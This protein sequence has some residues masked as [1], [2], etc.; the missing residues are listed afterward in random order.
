MPKIHYFQRY[1]KVEN[2]VTNNTLQLIARI[3]EYS[4]AQASRLLSELTGEAVEIGFEIN[5]QERA[6]ESVPDGAIIQRSFKILIESKVDSGI[7]EDQLLR[8]AKTF[9]NESQKI[10]LLLSVQK[11]IPGHERELANQI[12]TANGT[13]IIFRNVTY[14]EICNSIRDLFREYEY[15]MKTLVEDYIEYCNDTGLFDQSRHL[16]RIVPCSDSVD[17]NKKYGIYFHSSDRGYTNHSYVGIYAGK[18]V[19]CLWQLD[20]VFDVEYD[21]VNLTKT[22][23]QGKDTSDYDERIKNII[24]ES[25]KVCGYNVESGHRFFCGKKAIETDYSKSTPYGILSP[26]FINVKDVVGQFSD[27]EDLAIKLKGKTWE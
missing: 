4:N 22:L 12:S 2:M 17:L 6:N 25:K 16:M 11:M 7:D 13:G 21:G 20:S 18:K 1:S 5:Q 9:S 8:H 14:E 23:I 19:H 15:E 10:L 24:A 27:A 26:R 3:Y